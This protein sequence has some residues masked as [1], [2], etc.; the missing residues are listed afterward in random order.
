MDREVIEVI[1]IVLVLGSGIWFVLRPIAA[2]VARRIA[3]EVPAR[4]DARHAAA[5]LSD[6]HDEVVALRQEV[7]ELTERVDFTERLLARQQEAAR[8]ERPR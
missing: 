5:E 3:G 1:A 4:R 2:A 6:V 8:L 7:A